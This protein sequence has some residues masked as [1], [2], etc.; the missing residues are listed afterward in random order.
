MHL[1]GAGVCDALPPTLP[2]ITPAFLQAQ[3]N[4]ASRVV[5]FTKGNTRVAVWY[6]TG[7]VGTYLEHPRQGRTQLFRFDHMQTHPV[8]GLPLHTTQA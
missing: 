5:A 2:S 1:C 3:S 7:T 6:T 8:I 4:E